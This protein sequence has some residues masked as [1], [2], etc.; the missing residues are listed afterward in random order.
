MTPSAAFEGVE[1]RR[2]EDHAVARGDVDEV[3][4]DARPAILRVEVGEH[5][6]A[7]LD[8]DDDHLALAGDGE[9]GRWPARACAASACGTRMWSSAR[10]PAPEARGGGDVDAGVADRGRHLGERAGRVLDVDGQVDGHRGRE[11]NRAG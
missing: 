8:V 2:A 10:S 7:V 11:P 3:E 1:V 4:V 9:R 6:G 5:A